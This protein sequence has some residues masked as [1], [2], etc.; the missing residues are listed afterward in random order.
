MK[1]KWINII[2]FA[3]V[4][5][6]TMQLISQNTNRNF[7]KAYENK[8]YRQWQEYLDSSDKG[9][10]KYIVDER[11]YDILTGSYQVEH[12]VLDEA[13]EVNNECHLDFYFDEEARRKDIDMVMSVYSQLFFGRVNVI[14]S[15]P[16]ADLAQYKMNFDNIQLRIFIDSKLM[17]YKKYNLHEL[18]EDYYENMDY[19]VIS[20]Q[21]DKDQVLAF[22]D[23]VSELLG[24][25][26]V[27]EAQKPFKP[28][29][30]HFKIVT[31]EEVPADKIETIKSYV[32][33]TLALPLEKESK[34]IF[35]M[36]ANALGFVLSFETLDGQYQ[37]LLYFNGEEKAWI[38]DDWMSTDLFVM[39]GME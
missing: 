39:N 13:Y 1:N 14:G 2:L 21:K 38:E 30:Y 25:N 32:E 34:E 5:A 28:F 15:T 29:L 31:K 17:V 9:Q 35:G 12:L 3:A 27:V 36:N 37:E 10:R 24:E 18:K 19:Q 11:S 4:I 20:R 23:Q 22:K 16:Y 7:H 26:H 6:L 33:S 8:E